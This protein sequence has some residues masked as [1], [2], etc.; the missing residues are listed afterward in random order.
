MVK[1]DDDQIRKSCVWCVAAVVALIPLLLL[2]G[3]F[4][5]SSGD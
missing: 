5:F 4:L 3:W 2:L 1:S